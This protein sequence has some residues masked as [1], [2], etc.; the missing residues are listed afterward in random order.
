MDD[1]LNPYGGESSHLGTLEQKRSPSPP[2]LQPGNSST[3]RDSFSA[4]LKSREGDPQRPKP[5]SRSRSGSSLSHL[6]LVATERLGQETNRANAADLRCGEVLAHL[7]IIVQERDQ[8]RRTLAKVQ[9]ELGLYKLQLDVA[10]NEIFRAQ[11]IVDGVDKARVEAEEQAAKDRTIARQL[12]S[13]RAVWVARE[14]GRNEGFKEGLREGRRWASEAASRRRADEY[15]EDRYE[16]GEV[17]NDPDPEEYEPSVHS[18]S[19]SSHR[20]WSSPP[21]S[22]RSTFADAASYESTLPI[23]AMTPPAPAPSNVPPMVP[24]PP[25]PRIPPTR[26]ERSPSARS[27]RPL[28]RAPARPR[29]PEPITIRPDPNPSHTT[30]STPS[31]PTST[32]HRCVAVHP[33][34]FIPTLGADSIIALPPPHELS[35][36]VSVVGGETPRGADRRRTISNVSRGSTRISQYDILSPPRAS[37]TPVTRANEVVH[38]WRAANAEPTER[39]NSSENFSTNSSIPRARSSRRGPQRPREIVMPMPLSTS[40]HTPYAQPRTAPSQTDVQPSYTAPPD[41]YAPPAHPGPSQP[42][43]QAD[44]EGY[45]EDA[46]PARPR[47]AIAWIKTR[48]NRSFSTSSVPNIQIEPPSNPASNPSTEN[49]LNDILLTPD[50][51]VERTL[52]QHFV[53]ELAGAL[54]GVHAAQAQADGTG[55]NVIVLPDDELPPG[56]MPLSPILPN[57][58]SSIVPS[59]PAPAQ[60]PSP[61]PPAYTPR[62]IYAPLRPA[63]AGSMRLR[64]P[65]A[66]DA[67]SS[68]GRAPGT[69]I[70]SAMLQTSASPAPLNRPL[71]IF[72]SES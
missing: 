6:L 9:E 53:P 51:A 54:E 33:D 56:F 61:Q 26:P 24:H 8:L 1:N 66:S 37:E 47:S 20:A 5:R 12:V 42:P 3:L 4:Y 27:S 30:H 45:T 38:E 2:S 71:S 22:V 7:R 13:E 49:T 60:T 16:E 72:S 69:S 70:G 25:T 14:E 48:F 41:L 23:H 57:L 43:P 52:P 59:A 28:P 17:N 67:G 63:T 50:D 15:P 34:G 44:A 18:N 19:P 31:P 11:K 68:S 39:V 21:R 32:S 35:R 29:S 55:G 58:H 65:N 64:D 62:D 40:M 46:T 10:Q 36:P